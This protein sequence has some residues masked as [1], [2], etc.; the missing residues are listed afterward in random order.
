MLVHDTVIHNFV[1]CL[2]AQAVPASKG[3]DSRSVVLGSRI[4]DQ[5]IDSVGPHYKYYRDATYKLELNG[6]FI[7][8]DLLSDDDLVF[9][10]RQKA[11]A[12]GY[13]LK[14]SLSPNCRIIPADTLKAIRE[15]I[16]GQQ[17]E[18]P[19]RVLN[20]QYG[21]WYFYWI[22]LP[23]FSCDFQTAIVDISFMCGGDCGQ[24]NTYLLH[25]EKGKWV[26]VEK[27]LGWIS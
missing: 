26:V 6:K 9:I 13:S 23:L 19:S 8:T 16:S 17:Y 22:A 4:F 20:R 24:Q 7:K 15:R 10:E 1:R 18:S 3:K 12:C 11:T 5:D 25:K 27:C 2:L 14:Q 21:T